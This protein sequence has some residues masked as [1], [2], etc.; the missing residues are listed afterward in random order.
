MNKTLV[1]LII[2]FVTILCITGQSSAQTYPDKVSI[3]LPSPNNIFSA[4]YLNTTVNLYTGVPDI[5]LPLY[6]LES[7]E[8]KLPITLTYKASGVRLQ[9]VASVV[10]LNWNLTV[11][12]VITRIV[13]GLPDESEKGYIGKNRTGVQINTG[14]ESDQ[15]RADKIASGEYDGEPD[16]FYISTPTESLSFVFD[17]NGTALFNQPTRLTVAFQRT[18]GPDDNMNIT[19]TVVDE[20]GVRYIFGEDANSREVA[21]N[22]PNIPECN[23]TWHLSRMSSFNNTD[24]MTFSYASGRDLTMKTYN[25]I[26]M[27][28]SS[29]SSCSP[30]AGSV[31]NIDDERTY[32]APKYISS[33]T[34]N[35]GSVKFNY[36]TTRK[37]LIGGLQLFGIEIYNA[38][39]GDL[40]K[41]FVLN[42]DYFETVDP[43][44]EMNRLC[45][46][47]V[48]Q[49]SGND[50]ASIRLYDFNYY[51]NATFRFPPRSSVAFD[52]LGFYNNNSESTPFVPEANKQPDFD[53]TVLW[54]LRTIDHAQGGRTEFEYELNSWFD[55]V[56][57]TEKNSGGL[58]IKTI[59]EYD[60][61]GKVQTRTYE[62]KLDNGKSSGEVMIKNPQYSKITS[63][64]IPTGPTT[65]CVFSGESTYAGILFNIA[66]INNTFT[67]Y[68]RV[69]VTY[70]DG[71]NEVYL[72]TNFSSF[73]DKFIIINSLSGTS[74]GIDAIRQFGYPTS[75][76]Y[77]R[78]L[79]KFKGVYTASNHPVTE[80]SYE[81]SSLVPEQKKARGIA[82]SLSYTASGGANSN[83]FQ[84]I[85][86]Q[87]MES[88][89]VVKETEKIFDAVNRDVF[90]AK[91]K[92][93]E[94]SSN[95]T[96]IRK[97]IYNTSEGPSFY[98]KFYYPENKGELANLSAAEVQAY[99]IMNQLKVPIWE[100]RHAGGNVDVKYSMYKP[101]TGGAPLSTRVFPN[102]ILSSRNGAAFK[103]EASFTYD[104]DSGTL[105]TELKRNG[106]LNSFIWGRDTRLLA[107]AENAAIN[108]IY[109]Q[110]F[111]QVANS[112]T[113]NAF[114]GRKYFSGN[115][116]VVFTRPNTKNYQLSYWRF[117]NNVWQ[118]VVKDFTTDDMVITEPY[119]IDEIRV[120]PVG[121]RMS[122]YTG[123]PSVGITS[124]C[125]ANNTIQYFEYDDLLRLKLI[126]DLNA[127]ILSQY[128]YQYACNCPLNIPKIKIVFR[129]HY[130]E[131]IERY[132]YQTADVYAVMVDDNGAP[133]NIPGALLNYRQ[134]K[135]DTETGSTYEDKNIPV[136]GTETLIYS[137]MVGEWTYNISGNIATQWSYSFTPLLGIGYKL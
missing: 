90:V 23:S 61:T 99:S 21:T 16:L 109:Y 19:W 94:Y 31:T 62:Y 14:A 126:R 43:N 12:G 92:D 85:Y 82:L 86:Y 46:K 42:S 50:K 53:K 60:N 9:D 56:S 130:I 81:Y 35:N 27:K 95:G 77:K 88:Y 133:L 30:P 129:N 131:R 76:A 107:K 13:R 78:G 10:G 37:D 52:H 70:S 97:I 122:T 110:G 47:S 89:K 68:S 65:G 33:I 63:L 74:V 113:G 2:F 58:R 124:Y 96:L 100:E 4:S 119:P 102:K 105:L 101:V 45:L 1:K 115:Y 112:L 26:R 6:T 40:V 91:T 84:N 104:F 25:K 132:A 24:I 121:A 22:A 108:E 7:R 59:R 5:A 83:W 36:L 51:L 55:N 134:T 11:G 41:R 29:S 28:F 120:Y 117:V 87:S 103:E 114:A 3:T 64:I 71:G 18:N 34:T 135:N 69:K 38:I 79:P 20:L 137:G 39:H 116:R 48:Y 118:L 32:K 111:E 73:P 125:D 127:N 136:S 106:E 123:I 128:S 15:V 98:D 75:Y 57:N 66:D 80:I 8:L 44:P 17:E 49:V 54:T 67:G 93:Y 72:F